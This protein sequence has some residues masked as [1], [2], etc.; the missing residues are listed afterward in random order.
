MVLR[1]LMNKLQ[2][3]ARRQNNALRVD[4]RHSENY[5]VNRVAL[6]TRL[7]TMY[8][9]GVITD[10]AFTISASGIITS[11]SLYNGNSMIAVFECD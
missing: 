10:W 2:A 1:E 7:E 11:I 9:C 5:T 3:D 6:N 8:A 4:G